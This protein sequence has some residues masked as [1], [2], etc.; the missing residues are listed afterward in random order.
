MVPD[1]LQTRK[2]YTNKKDLYYK[3]ANLWITPQK[4]SRKRKNES[5][6]AVFDSAEYKHSR[7]A[8]FDYVR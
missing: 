7:Q 8:G 4:T 6:F 1:S 3:G 2:I 5:A